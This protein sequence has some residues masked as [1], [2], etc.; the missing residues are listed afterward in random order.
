MNNECSQI[1]ANEQG[2]KYDKN[3]NTILYGNSANMK[4]IGV[5]DGTC[6]LINPI[7]YDNQH[8]CGL[9]T[10]G[11][12]YSGWLYGKKKCS[13]C[14]K[15]NSDFIPNTQFRENFDIGENINLNYI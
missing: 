15:N 6:N 12:P 1:W 2:A 10:A 14:P 4:A 7:I 3:T 9:G 5:F 11:G 13:N 8:K